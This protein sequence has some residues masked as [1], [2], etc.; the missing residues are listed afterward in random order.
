MLVKSPELNINN[1]KNGKPIYYECNQWVDVSIVKY[2]LDK[3]EVN[4]HIEAVAVALH[5]FDLDTQN[6]NNSQFRC[7]IG[8]CHK[9]EKGTDS[10]ITRDLDEHLR[11]GYMAGDRLQTMESY[12]VDNVKYYKTTYSQEGVP[13]NCPIVS[14]YVKMHQRLLL[15]EAINALMA[16]NIIP[17]YVAVDGIE[18]AKEHE[19]KARRI[20]TAHPSKWVKEAIKKPLM[21][22]VG[23]LQR[24]PCRLPDKYTVEN[25][26]GIEYTDYEELFKPWEDRIELPKL[27]HI[28]GAAGNGK[29]HRIIE[30]AKQY[31]NI[32]ITAT[33]YNA[34]INMDNRA[35]EQNI[36]IEIDNTYHAVFNINSRP[37][38]IK[39]NSI[40]L[41][42][43][44]SMLPLEHLNMINRNLQERFNN[45]L[46]PFG[47]RHIILVGDFHQLP[48]I[49]PYKSLYD[50]FTN[51]SSPIYKLFTIQELTKNYRQ[52]EDPDFF[53][54]CQKMRQKMTHGDC[55]EL[56]DILNA[57]VADTEHMQGLRLVSTN[58]KVDA[59]NTKYYNNE[60]NPGN[61]IINT[62]NFKD[63]ASGRFIPNG[64]LGVVNA[65]GK[66]DFDGVKMTL[67]KCFKLAA[68]ITIHRSQGLTVRENIIIDPDR[69]FDKN[70]L[71]VALTRAIKLDNVYLTQPIEI[72]T[73]KRTCNI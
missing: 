28:A 48:V 18:I 4:P 42:E 60:F 9:T 39:N 6:M 68:G 2:N 24:A 17:V 15:F 12:T 73:I 38:P 59:L 51:H 45:H 37:R 66:A 5:H 65:D 16:V 34:L 71:Y 70:H 46:E 26:H 44:C 19:Q 41:I 54:L 52:Q 3:Y 69:L 14:L 21:Q 10:W 53:N 72:R 22:E 67:K 32:K 43:E 30:I 33:T 64:L 36:N 23:I 13:W 63:K 50:P 58:E 25:Y 20:L 27:L 40:F 31:K 8:K 29:T 7:F 61:C 56:M 35:K 57:R 62:E 49:A 55:V 1:I 11:A 47:G